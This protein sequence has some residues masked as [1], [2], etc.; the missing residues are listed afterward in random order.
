MARRQPSGAIQ[1]AKTVYLT[2]HINTGLKSELRAL[3]NEERRSLTNFI[4]VRLD[5]IASAHRGKRKRPMPLRQTRDGRFM[6]RLT[7]ELKS[8]L[9]RLAHDNYR[10]LT[11]FIEMELLKTVSA[12]KAMLTTRLLVVAPKAKRLYLIPRRQVRTARLGICIN[13]KLKAQLQRLAVEDYRTLPNFV[14]IELYHIVATHKEKRERRMPRR[15]TRDG[16]LTMRISAELKA[17]LQ[18][19]ADKDFRTLTDFTEIALRRI[20]AARKGK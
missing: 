7:E 13:A 19:L 4:E 17:N 16:R 8:D 11:G 2:M 6:L 9:H 1:V 18:E 5:K 3:A 10:T 15:Q 20:V 12:R 14:E